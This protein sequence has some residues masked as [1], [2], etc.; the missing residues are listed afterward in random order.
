[1]WDK[2]SL[3]DIEYFYDYALQYQ[4]LPFIWITIQIFY[5][6]E[7]WVAKAQAE[8]ALHYLTIND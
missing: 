2:A 7:E 4:I 6:D 3:P 5:D 1:M 8:E